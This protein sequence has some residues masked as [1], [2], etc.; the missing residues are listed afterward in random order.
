ML[1]EPASETNFRC[2]ER[3]RRCLKSRG[4]CKA[5]L[6]FGFCSEINELPDTPRDDHPLFEVLTFLLQKTV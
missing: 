2:Y 5:G 3:R 4:W 6:D 1:N